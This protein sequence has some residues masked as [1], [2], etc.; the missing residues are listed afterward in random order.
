MRTL[1]FKLAGFALLVSA[2]A[3]AQPQQ[4][5]VAL[6]ATGGTIA[7]KIDPVKKAP[8]P[9]ISG[10]DLL[11][12]VPEVAKYAKVEV[13]NISNVP[14]DYMDPPRWIQLTKAVQASLARPEVAGVIV[15]HGTD[16]LEETAYWLD[17]TVN[18]DKPVVLI[19]AQR[20]A[21][22]S[23]FDGPHN[24]INAVRIAVEPQARSK[25]VLLA[26]NS[27]INAA[28][29]ATK[30]HTS[31]V[32]TFKSGEFGFLG[33]VDYDRV[34]FARAPLRRLHIPIRTDK[35]PDVEIVAMYGGAD[36]KLVRSAVDNGAKGLVIQALGW[37][38][39]NIPM[40]N[41]VK[42]ALSKNVPVVISTRVPTGRVLPNY[43]FEGGG[44]TLA[45]AGAVMAD[46][47]SPQKARILLM[48]MLQGGSAPNQRDLQA[49][50]SH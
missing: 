14:S 37:G 41:A 18:S 28:R 42:Y 35:M 29:E 40:F 11:A 5:V 13:N 32:E 49:A 22:E 4:P 30:T 31:S 48:L 2:A 46:D 38:N 34:T 20:N 15:S 24:L 26:M 23:D 45:D 33:V 16:T 17:L 10:E 3:I 39:V 44:K 21:S 12:T 1:K 43:G 8:V 36:G 9:A 7:M 27:Q 19:G 25:G 47:L 50:F 6:I